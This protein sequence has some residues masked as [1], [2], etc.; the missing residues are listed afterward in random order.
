V[1]AV[2]T[3]QQLL[4]RSEN[5]MDT[6]K[7]LWE[8]CVDAVGTLWGRYVHAITDKFD[9]LSVFRGDPTAR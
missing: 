1:R 5:F 3:L 9:I 8:R 6:V 7:T 4:A 2:N